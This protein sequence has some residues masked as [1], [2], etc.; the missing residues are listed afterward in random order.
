MKL[1]AQGSYTLQIYWKGDPGVENFMIKHTNEENLTHWKKTLQKQRESFQRPEGRGRG[2]GGGAPTGFLWMAGAEATENI[3]RVRYTADSDDD[4]DD[5]Q[6]LVNGSNMSLRSFSGSTLRS[7]SGTNENLPTPSQSYSR[8][9]PQRYPPPGHTPPLTLNTNPAHYNITNSPGNQ[10]SYFSPIET[11]QLTS[12]ASSSSSQQY[13]FPRY[14]NPPSVYGDDPNR[15]TPPNM[16]R[17]SS[18]EGSSLHQTQ[19]QAYQSRQAMQRPSLPGMQNSGT[20]AAAAAAQNRMRSASSPNIHHVPNPSNLARNSPGGIIPPVPSVPNTYIPYSP[21]VSVGVNRSDTGS[22]TSPNLPPHMMPPIART[23]S[24]GGH[25]SIGT[26]VNGASRGPNS[27]VKVKIH[28]NDDKLAIIV[29]YNIAY[30]QLMD[31]IERK[32]RICGSGPDIDRNA[33]IRIRY[34]DEDGDFISMHS[35]D[36]V[37]MAFDVSC[38]AGSSDGNG[39]CG[40]IT[41]YVTAG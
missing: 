12:R 41:L 13:P 35:D 24:P 31:R 27:Q 39:T 36:D 6:T 20:A 23:Q 9:P 22:P 18:R 38:E 11:P 17:S 25:P 34:Q 3:D 29:P 32:V 14:P 4:D 8:P 21:A 30:S 19:Y 26:P 16:S 33:P 10:D 7:R 40:A 28:Y 37:Q 5:A 2:S 1:I 15:Y